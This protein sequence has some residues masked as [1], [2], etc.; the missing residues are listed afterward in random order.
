MNSRIE[1]RERI[2]KILSRLLYVH[3]NGC[4]EWCCEHVDGEDERFVEE[5]LDG[6]WEEMEKWG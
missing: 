1:L 3:C 5:V 2:K 6:I 4:D